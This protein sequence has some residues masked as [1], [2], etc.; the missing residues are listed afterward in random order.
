[1]Q[2]LLGTGLVI[3]EDK[4]R[5][6][7]SLSWQLSAWGPEPKPRFII[8]VQ[9]WVISDNLSIFLPFYIDKNAQIVFRLV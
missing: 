2:P 3:V 4:K 1:M 6:V 5:N 9:L 7:E 8:E